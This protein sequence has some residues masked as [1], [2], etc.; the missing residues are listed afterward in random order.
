MHLRAVALI[1]AIVL[2]AAL[3]CGAPTILGFYTPAC[4]TFGNLL[5][6][7]GGVAGAV[8]QSVEYYARS[9]L[10]LP[11]AHGFPPF[12]WATFTDGLYIPTSFDIITM[13]DAMGLIGYLK[14]HARALAGRGGNAT[15]ALEAAIFLGDYLTS[16]TLTPAAGAWANISRSTGLNIEWPLITA[17]QGDITFGLNCIE[18]DRVAMTGFA[19]LKLFEVVPD[20]RYLTQAVRS[21][22]VLAAKQVAG[23]ATDAPWPFRVDAVTGAFLNGHKNG[24]SAFPL[25]L[26]RALAA[27]PYSM[28]EFSAPA[29]RLW[30]WVR[31]FQ[32][33]TA[34]PNVSKADALFVNFFEDR[35]TTLD[36]NRNSWTAME[37][38]RLLV[39][40]REALDIDWR[41]H[42]EDIFSYALALFGHASGVG[43]ATIMGEQ[44]DDNK[45]WGGAN[46]KLAGVASKYACAGGP[47]WY[48]ALGRL[49]ANHMAHYTDPA[50]GCRSA[51]AY[52][53]NAAPTRGGWTEDGWLDVLHNLV[54]YLDAEDGVC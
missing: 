53:V 46:S 42:V 14:L 26:F 45:P 36:N 38:A 32:L 25:R 15:A 48:G 43:N 31:D 2:S 12:V 35:E 22:R 16:W 51:E 24:E 41:A 54:D 10:N 7:P 29:E 20:A 34:I 6:P 23:N 37:L 17:S 47:A 27:A 33:P 8:D 4:D 3:P 11:L 50:D 39:E 19:L 30:A 40:E 9:P 18:T 28:A 21:A 49:N 13:Q 44:D 52:L 1:G 5:P